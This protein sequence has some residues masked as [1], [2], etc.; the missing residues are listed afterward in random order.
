MNDQTATDAMVRFPTTHATAT[1]LDEIRTFFDDD[2]VHMALI[3]AGDG[4]L[5]TTLERDDLTVALPGSTPA[6]NLGTLTGRTAAPAQPLETATAALQH[7]RRR[8]L[9]V[10][11][12]SGHLLGLLCLKR[13]E[14]GYCSDEGIR[15]RAHHAERSRADSLDAEPLQRSQRG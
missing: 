8:R 5:V 10:I 6:R 4:H 9:A 1:S 2:H 3:V 11:D 12:D 14:T 7:Q 13:N 15:A